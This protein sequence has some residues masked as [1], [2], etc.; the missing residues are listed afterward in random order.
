MDIN[1]AAITV[2]TND[3]ELANIDFSVQDAKATKYP[4]NFFDGVIEQAVLACMEKPDRAAVLKEVHRILKSGGIF[5]IAEFGMKKN[6]EEKYKADALI[7]GE[8]GTMII[9]KEDGSEWFRSH[10]FTKDELGTLIKDSRFEV[11][12]YMDPMFTTLHGN[13]HPGH[14]YIVRKI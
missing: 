4:S 10:N 13:P 2:A 11:I 3:P 6:R 9:R 12:E 5:S 8:Y 7:A 14:Q 1:K